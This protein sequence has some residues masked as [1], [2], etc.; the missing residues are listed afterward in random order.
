MYIPSLFFCEESPLFGFR[1][2]FRS[3]PHFFR[4]CSSFLVFLSLSSVSVSSSSEARSVARKR[5]SRGRRGRGGTNEEYPA[6][7]RRPRLIYDS[8][9]PRCSLL[10]VVAVV[11]AVVLVLD[12][13]IVLLLSSVIATDT[14]KV[15][16]HGSSLVWTRYE[17]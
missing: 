13:S 16:T 11:V 8:F 4:S 5:E 1:H 7:V 17:E 10:P 9:S 2:S 14:K 15:E 3:R 12:V 6:I